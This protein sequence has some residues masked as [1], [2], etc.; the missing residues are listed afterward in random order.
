MS[1]GM[2]SSWTV[3]INHKYVWWSTASVFP[4]MISW[5]TPT[6]LPLIVQCQLFIIFLFDNS[7]QQYFNYRRH[8]NVLGVADQIQFPKSNHLN[9]TT[10]QM[11]FNVRAGVMN[12]RDR[13]RDRNLIDATLKPLNSTNLNSILAHDTT[14]QNSVQPTKDSSPRILPPPQ[15]LTGNLKL[16]SQGKI[17]NAINASNGNSKRRITD[18]KSVGIA[19][20]NS[21]NNNNVGTTHKHSD[22]SNDLVLPNCPGA[23]SPKKSNSNSLKKKLSTLSSIYQDSNNH[24]LITPVGHLKIH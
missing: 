14:S 24:T 11:P 6:C 3:K 21:N 18:W 2:R 5:P 15:W 8:S 17:G 12:K 23:I 4:V 7:F 9:K 16:T 20:S 10:N 1:L 19:N 22:S 13:E